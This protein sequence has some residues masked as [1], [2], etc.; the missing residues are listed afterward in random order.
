MPASLSSTLTILSRG[1]P[2]AYAEVDRADRAEA[3]ATRLQQKLDAE[4]ALS[5]S[6]QQ[7]LRATAASAQQAAQQARVLHGA[8]GAGGGGP[9]IVGLERQLA[10]LRDRLDA[11]R[12]EKGEL[13]RRAAA[14]SAELEAERRERHALAAS[15]EEERRARAR[16]AEELEKARRLLREAG[17]AHDEAVAELGE[18]TI[19][20][21]RHKAHGAAAHAALRAALDAERRR[22]A[23]AAARRAAA[24]ALAARRGEAPPSPRASE[25][26]CASEADAAE[27]PAEL[28][29]LP[30]SCSVA[31]IAAAAAS[32]RAARRAAEARAA[33]LEA[34]L[35]APRAA[36]EE[37]AEATARL[38]T[39]AARVGGAP[40]GATAREYVRLLEA[41]VG[42]EEGARGKENAAAGGNVCARR[43]GGEGRGPPAEKW[44]RA[45]HA[46]ESDGLP[47]EEASSAVAL[48]SQQAEGGRHTSL[49]P[50]GAQFEA[51]PRHEAVRQKLLEAAARQ[52]RREARMQPLLRHERAA[53]VEAEEGQL[54]EHDAHA[55]RP[56]SAAHLPVRPSTGRGRSATMRGRGHTLYAARGGRQSAWH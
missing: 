18:L 19:A 12:K 44:A 29:P 10:S 36:A 54:E 56:P 25:S 3:R 32:E 47:R 34:E 13:A 6:L 53:A 7:Q 20:H 28:E 24:D 43:D 35:R 5:A 9:S 8:P 50:T 26:S 39:L 27:P 11:E 45:P 46:D 49:R 41:A 30:P 2:D 1:A 51:E 17:R 52:S 23:A 22:G 14:L 55:R 31:A 15:R 16:T 38:A 42:A 37:L 33:A 4:R 48:E 21:G 40:A